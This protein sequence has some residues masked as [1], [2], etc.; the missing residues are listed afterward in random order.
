MGALGPVLTANVVI[1][2]HLTLIPQPESEV[3]NSLDRK[4][5]HEAL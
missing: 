3:T 4:Q 5:C 2:E 1:L